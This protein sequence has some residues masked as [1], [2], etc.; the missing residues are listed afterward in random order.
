M[1]PR[2]TNSRIMRQFVL[3]SINTFS[4]ILNFQKMIAYK[5]L[6]RMECYLERMKNSKGGL[7]HKPKQSQAPKT[8]DKPRTMYVSDSN[9][10]KYEVSNKFM[11]F[12]AEEILKISCEGKIPHSIFL[13]QKLTSLNWLR[14]LPLIDSKHLLLR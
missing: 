2:P 7:E 13:A 12:P 8:R 6:V 14:N 3:Y 9:L 1:I 5:D 11:S 4:M 10:S